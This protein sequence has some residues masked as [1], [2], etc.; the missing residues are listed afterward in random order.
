MKGVEFTST[1]AEKVIG[2]KLLLLLLQ[3][4][5]QKQIEILQC[6]ITT[7]GLVQLV[8]VTVE[9]NKHPGMIPLISKQLIMTSTR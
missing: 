4:K 3:G 6:Y 1:S 5:N 2:H 9:G 8:P 7:A